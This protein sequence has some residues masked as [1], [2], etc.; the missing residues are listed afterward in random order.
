MVSLFE[1]RTNRRSLA[2]IGFYLM[3]FVHGFKHLK[4]EDIL[5]FPTSFLQDEFISKHLFL[6][7]KRALEILK[8]IIELI[9]I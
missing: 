9:I 1:Q 3:H 4:V 2:V 6:R 8:F 7:A 5:Q